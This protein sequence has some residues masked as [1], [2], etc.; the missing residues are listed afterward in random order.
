MAAR[1]F[2]NIGANWGDTANWSDTSGGA[3]GFSVPTSADD[4]YFD[5]NSGNCAVNASNRVCANL[6]FTG[7]ANTITFTFRITISGSVFT[8]SNTMTI[9]GSSGVAV[10]NACTLTSNGK[11]FN[12]TLF[13]NHNLVSPIVDFTLA[14]DWT[15]FNL[16]TLNG[17]SVNGLVGNNLYITGDLTFVFRGLIDTTSVTPTHIHMIGTGNITTA[18]FDSISNI[19]RNAFTINTSGTITFVGATSSFAYG[20]S[21][22]NPIF[23][24]LSGTIIVPSGYTLVLTESQFNDQVGVVWS[25][26]IT[27]DLTTVTLLSDLY[28]NG[29]HTTNRVT[30]NGF[31]V[32][33]SG[34]FLNTIGT[35]FANTTNYHLI[36]TG[37]WSATGSGGF[38]GNLT[39][40]TSGTIT[41]SGT[42]S[43][44]ISGTLE[45]I[46]GAVVTTGSTLNIT[47]NC[48]LNTNSITW[49]MVNITSATTSL[50]INSLLT[51]NSIQLRNGN[52]TFA[53]TSGFTT[54]TLEL[55]D[56]LTTTRTYTFTIGNTY[57]VNSQLTIVGTTTNRAVFASS[58]GVTRAVL[59]LFGSQNVQ[60]TNAT[61]INSSGGSTIYTTANST[62][63][64]TINW[65]LG[66]GNNWF[67]FLNR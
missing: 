18:G 25:N 20:F 49:N 53:G 35:A 46:S 26:L 47:G 39:I 62:L 4:V 40:N 30:L 24:I 54:N 45:H 10:T 60:N 42:V 66:N 32:Y 48:T 44:G 36:G 43:Y 37:T 8:L 55:V 23:S 31:N 6:D 59:N 57:N 21:G 7:Y 15:V 64:D 1:Y 67:F 9:A 2:L 28:L 19:R 58:S 5:A 16:Q 29:T 12:A 56:T 17:N 63:T 41:V 65:G 33:N 22:S 51:A 38:R 11:T 27:V 13:L 3:G 52:L 14:D 61:R 50:T 34:N